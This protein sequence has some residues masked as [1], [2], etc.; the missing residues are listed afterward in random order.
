MELPIQAPTSAMIRDPNAADMEARKGAIKRWPDGVFWEKGLKIKPS[1]RLVVDLPL[2]PGRAI[3]QIQADANDIYIVEAMDSAGKVTELWRA[4]SLDKVWGL[5]TRKSGHVDIPPGTEKMRVR[6][7]DGDSAYAVSWVAVTR[8]FSFRLLHI[9]GGLWLLW[10]LLTLLAT[11]GPGARTRGVSTRLLAGWA[12]ADTALAMVLCFY[13]LFVASLITVAAGLILLL[14]WLVAVLIKRSITLTAMAGLT[15]ALL[16]FLVITPVVKT[17]VRARVERLQVLDLEHRLKPHGQPDINADG[18][19]L[20]G[21]SKDVREQDF[22]II[23]LGDSFTYGWSLEY[24]DTFTS[25]LEEITRSS[26]CQRKVRA[27]NFGWPGAS[28]IVAQRLLRQ[29]GKRYK[30]DLVVYN[31]DMT[32]FRDD[33]LYEDAL[34]R[35]GW[36]LE[37]DVP[38]LIWQAARYFML[39][40]TDDRDKVDRL[41]SSLRQAAAPASS[42]RPYVPSERFFPLMYPLRETQARMEAGTMKYLEQIR[43][44]SKETLGVPMAM[45]IFPRACQY[46]KREAPR[47]WEHDCPVMGEYVLEP[48][49]YLAQAKGKL[50]YPVFDL[51]PDFKSAKQFPLYLEDDP[52]WNPVG[53]RQAARAAARYLM[54]SK[55]IPC[56]PKTAEPLLGLPLVEQ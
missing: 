25:K 26:Q 3:V 50:G 37:P 6:G 11:M 4:P 19:R 46:S 13:N 10:V 47:N 39:A 28:P 40:I 38:T 5:T 41:Q 31:L 1:E 29:V 24:E 36:E 17:V 12:R 22:N 15:C 55:L 32:D 34:E 42:K 27:L 53:A 21:E 52:H 56:T 54:E 51:L 48:N 44:Y 2:S 49:R 8:V 20:M 35:N 43:A 30:P 7:K 45:I 33:L 16:Y 18:I 9:A 23:F 14:L